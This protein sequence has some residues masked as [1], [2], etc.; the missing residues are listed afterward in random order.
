MCGANKRFLLYLL[1]ALL[2]ASAAGVLRAEERET[3]Y[4]ISEMELRSIEAYKR[5]SE[6]EKQAW[7]LQ[8]Q[9]LKAQAAGLRKDSESLNDQFA[10]Q[11][12]LN[13]SLRQS[14]NEYEAESLMTISLK[15]GEIADLKK[16]AEKHK[17]A[18]RSRLIV[19]IALAGSWVVFIAFK[20]CRF[21]RFF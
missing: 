6:A 11:R 5:K 2:L 12:E 1:F 7:L 19:I 4:L 20:M 8:V 15:N 16:E 13:R 3:W 17:G 10:S 21:L 9:G 18:S 14:F